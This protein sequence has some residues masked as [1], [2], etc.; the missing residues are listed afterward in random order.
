[1]AEK[2]PRKTVLSEALGRHWLALKLQDVYEF[3]P[4][5]QAVEMDSEDAVIPHTWANADF[6]GSFTRQRGELE[7]SI[8]NSGPTLKLKGGGVYPILGKSGSGKSRF[9]LKHLHLSAKAAGLKSVYIKMH[10]PGDESELLRIEP[11]AVVPDFEGALAFNL[12]EAMSIDQADLIIIDS[13]RYLFYS[14]SGGATGKGGVNMSLFMDL[15]HLDVLAARLGVPIFVVI[16]PMT[17]DEAAF[18][19]YVE[20]AVGATTGVFI[21][22]NFMKMRYTDR[23]LASREFTQLS[24]PKYT[25][26]DKAM[27]KAA[28]QGAVTLGAATGGA[29]QPVSSSVFGRNNRP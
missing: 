16:N 28:A 26:V 14:S 19:F 6:I 15:T 20:A 29:A 3:F 8:L 25:T 12:A 18:N 24:L 17:D 10:E 7:V 23:N 4:N 22:D 5:R 9:A 2:L 13:L 27:G 21:M 11:D 1:M